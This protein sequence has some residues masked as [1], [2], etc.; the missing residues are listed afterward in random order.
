MLPLLIGISFLAGLF[1]SMLGLGGGIFLVPA[2]TLLL[3]LP[4][5][6]AIAASIVAVVATST[7]STGFYLKAGMTNVRLGLVLGAG[8]ALGALGGGMVA[9]SFEKQVLDILFGSVALLAAVTMVLRSQRVVGPAD[10][11]GIAKHEN[12]PF[13]NHV[14]GFLGVGGGETDEA[15]PQSLPRAATHAS[16]AP[17]ELS[18]G[19]LD[20]ATGRVVFYRVQKL[21]FGLIT[22]LVGGCISGALGIGGGVVQV[23]TMSLVMHVPVKAAVATSSFVVGITV[24]ASAFIYLGRGYIDPATVAM[25][26]LGILAGASVGPRLAGRM[27]SG[28]LTWMFAAMLLYV[29][30][31]MLLQGFVA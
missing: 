25:V 13:Q 16:Y 31:R 11:V 29:A 12:S 15:L 9:L 17:D 1:G 6:T 26:T 23:P 5:K 8:A 28:M 4:L 10:T 18:G 30:I 20:A 22:S 2:L 14:G 27:R 3:H 24:V 7:A 19:Y 21:G